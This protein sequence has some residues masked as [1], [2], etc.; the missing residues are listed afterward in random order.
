MSMIVVPQKH[1][2]D[3]RPFADLAEDPEKFRRAMRRFMLILEQSFTVDAR[4]HGA[5]FAQRHKTDSEIKRRA[6]ILGDW[7]RRLRNL[8]YGHIQTM[9][10]LPKALR[11]ALDGE[12]YT[13]PERSRL[14]VPEGVQ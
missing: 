2:A 8:G 14:W 12:S 6:N 11:A 4:M 1:R 13:P 3:Q 9:D 5:S 7:Y 10:E